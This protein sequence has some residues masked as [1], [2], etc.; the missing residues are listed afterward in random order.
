MKITFVFLSI[1]FILYMN[2]G[3]RFETIT[4]RFADLITTYIDKSSKKP[5]NV[6]LGYLM[7][8]KIKSFWK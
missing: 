1:E 2:K 7:S 6:I 8:L 3:C 4:Y 5:H